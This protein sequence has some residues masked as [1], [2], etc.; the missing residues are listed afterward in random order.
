MNPI[1]SLK[2]VAAQTRHY[3]YWLL[4]LGYWL[5]KKKPKH[6]IFPY[7]PQWIQGEHIAAGVF[8]L[9]SLLVSLHRYYRKKPSSCRY[10]FL[11]V[12]TTD[13]KHQISPTVTLIRQKV[14]SLATIWISR[15]PATIQ[16]RTNIWWLQLS[17][18]KNVTFVEKLVFS[19][20]NQGL[21]LCTFYR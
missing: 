6:P 9:F 7:C 11:N 15:I 21:C 14:L 19:H 3:T 17:V 8:F 2:Y 4:L 18:M 20:T 5:T 1:I 12:W 13:E 16:S 10:I